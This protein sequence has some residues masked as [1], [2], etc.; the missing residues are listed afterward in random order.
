MKKSILW[1]IL[2]VLAATQTAALAEGIHGALSYEYS[3]KYIWRGFDIFNDKSGSHPSLNLDLGNGFGFNL[4]SHMANASGFV[5]TE[6]WDYNVYYRN[7]AF[8][9]ERHQINYMLGYVYYN[10]PDMSG[11]T[12][13]SIDLQEIHGVFSFPN[14]LGVERLVPTYCLVKLWPSNSGT[15]VGANSPVGGTASGWAHIFMLDYGMKIQCPI[16]NNDRILN[17]HS[18]FIFNDGVGPNGANADHDWSNTV[19]GIST[20]FEL[21]ENMIFTPG[22]HHQITMDKSV[23]ADKDETW[24]SF[25]FMLKF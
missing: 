15:L 12:T 1:V 6:R 3:T 11:H 25:K 24:A 20:D 22:I 18:E 4:T 7:A 23:N 9:G 5:N 16:T 17:L 19:L 10:Y 2:L 14:L 8:A 13:A 21:A